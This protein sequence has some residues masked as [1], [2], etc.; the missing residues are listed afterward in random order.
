MFDN[1]ESVF[2]YTRTFK[3][4]LIKKT[5]CR[6][7]SKS[8]HIWCLLD[9]V[10]EKSVTFWST[11]CTHVFPA[12]CLSLC[13]F[14]CTSLMGCLRDPA[15]VQRT[16]SNSRVFWTHLLEVC[17][18][19]AGSCKHCM[20]FI[21]SAASC[22]FDRLCAVSLITTAVISPRTF[23]HLKSHSSFR[24]RDPTCFC[25]LFASDSV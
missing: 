19:F 14:V 2:Q 1:H 22:A 20:S 7:C 9:D 4:W 8:I 16:S 13:L 12:V 15:N 17:W 21:G 24:R 18:T 10:F 11:V 5:K 25:F 3:L 23:P 6:N